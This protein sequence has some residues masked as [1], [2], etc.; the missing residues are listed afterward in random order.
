MHPCV[1][2]TSAAAS[3][4]TAPDLDVPS[5]SAR[6]FGLALVALAMGGFAI[7]PWVSAL[8]WIVTAIILALNV[9]LLYDTLTGAGG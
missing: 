6:H 3:T 8:S 4:D 2:M 7:G 5:V 1:T 9:K